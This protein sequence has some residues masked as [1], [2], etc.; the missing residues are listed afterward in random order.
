MRQS[1]TPA[2]APVGDRTIKEVCADARIGRTTLEEWLAADLLR[3]QDDRRFQ[4][5]RWRG[6]KRIWSP[7]AY[8][9]LIEAIEHESEPGGVLAHRGRSM[10]S[11]AP[12]I[13]AASAKA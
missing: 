1:L 2:P 8:R 4:F 11:G 6:R 9:K 3:P 7:E 5:H 12:A 10:I 13:P